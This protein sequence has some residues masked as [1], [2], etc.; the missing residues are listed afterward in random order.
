MNTHDETPVLSKVQPWCAVTDE[1]ILEWVG[2]SVSTSTL[3]DCAV[4]PE[5]L[6]T[7]PPEVLSFK[8]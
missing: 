5:V 7:V 2:E 8:M 6:S 4:P 3:S 1:Q